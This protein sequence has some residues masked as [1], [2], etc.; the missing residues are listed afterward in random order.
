MTVRAMKTVPSDSAHMVHLS[1]TSADAWNVLLGEVRALALY[2]S[3]P[4][5]QH[6][7]PQLVMHR[8]SFLK[9][10]HKAIHLSIDTQLVAAVPLVLEGLVECM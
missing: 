3:Y 10:V 5:V 4:S 6:A 2:C 7:L 8:N 1:H 9:S